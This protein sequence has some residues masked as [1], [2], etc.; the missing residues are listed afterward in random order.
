MVASN[1]RVGSV[2]D[3]M[4]EYFDDMETDERVVV[5]NELDLEWFPDPKEH[6]IGFKVADIDKQTHD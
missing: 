1:L 2:E 5:K 4:M 3:E 6:C